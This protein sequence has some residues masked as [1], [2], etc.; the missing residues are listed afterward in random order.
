MVKLSDELAKFNIPLAIN[1]C[2]FNI[3]RR[4]PETHGLIKACRDRGI[5]FQSYPSLSQGRLTGKC[6]VEKPPP[7]T[8]RFSK[9][10]MKAIEPTQSVLRDIAKAR[11]KSMSAVA[12]NHNISKS[13]VPTVVMRGP[14]RAEDNVAALGW[15]LTEEEMKKNHAVSLEGNSTVLWQQG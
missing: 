13:A 11:E 3:L 1:Q 2:Q 14:K 7:K 6:T 8:C 4:Y 5:L 15:R 12:L 9:Y 10:G